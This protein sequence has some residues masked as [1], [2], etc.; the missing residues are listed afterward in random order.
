MD[1]YD[2][3]DFWYTF[4]NSQYNFELS[5]GRGKLEIAEETQEKF[6]AYFKEKIEK[7]VVDG[8]TA[9]PPTLFDYFWRFP[10]DMLPK[11]R[12]LAEGFLEAD[13]ENAAALMILTIVAGEERDSEYQTHLETLMRLVPKDPGTNLI[14]INEFHRNYGSLKGKSDSLET[15]LTVLENLYEWAKQEGATDRYQDVKSTYNRIGRSPGTPYSRTKKKLLELK[16][17]SENPANQKERRDQIEQCKVRI[18]R[19]INLFHKEHAAFQK[20]SLQESDDM[21]DFGD[22]TSEQIDFWETYLNSLDEGELSS[23]NW[24]LTP[25]IQTQLLT[26][27]KTQI[28]VGVVDGQT[29]LPAELQKYVSRFPK[30]IRIELREFA[31]EILEKQPNNGAAAKLLAILV[32]DKEFPYFEQ[33]IELLPNDAEMCFFAIKRFSDDDNAFFEKTLPALERLFACAQ[34][35]DGSEL[36]HWH[37]KLYQETGRTPCHIYRKLM[38]HAEANSELIERCKPLI[39][40]AEKVFLQRLEVESDDWYALRGL[41]DI[42]QTLGETEL[43]KKYPW[44]PHSEFRWNQKAWEGLELPN[45]SATTLDGAPFSFSDYHGK[46]VLLNF[47]AWWCGPCKTE[48]PYVKQVYEEHHQNGLE[49]IRIS[50]DESEADLRN[51]IEEHEIPGIQLFENDGRLKGPA[52]FFGIY[53]IPSLW[54]IDRDGKIISVSSRQDRLVQKVNWTESSRVGDTVP[55]FSAVDIDGNAV[56]PITFRGK[57]VLLILGFPEK[58][59]NGV[60]A[61][62]EKYHPKGFEIIVINIFGWPNEEAFREVVHEDYI[63]GKVNCD[64]KRPD[65][66][67][68][69]QFGMWFGRMCPAVVLIDKDGKIIMSRYGQVHSPEAWAA[70]LE[71]LVATHL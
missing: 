12:S 15:F 65:S 58:I 32:E 22:L 55:D 31:E 4:L 48:I 49:V 56:S 45:F 28:E 63:I 60:H 64:A 30:V 62:Y 10:Q 47:C 41:G 7:G 1:K 11:L 35:Q 6:L 46:L 54:L 27:F 25:T 37:T 68:A 8:V 5:V 13:P 2:S 14:I 52:K 43:A 39:D 24:K 3:T 26:Y 29:T 70:K 40:Q 36:Y 51:Y 23:S 61:I 21:Q 69:R 34:Q 71:E 53:G 18:K 16:N 42:Y 38:Q 19:C 20:E 9:L 57:V 44:E 33:A 17:D 66:P 50:V 59:L 67:M